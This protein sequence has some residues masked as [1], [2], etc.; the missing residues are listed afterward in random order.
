M[1]FDT[2]GKE[3][4]AGSTPA[5][6]HFKTKYLASH[7][8]KI[9]VLE[10]DLTRLP[11]PEE[12]FF[13]Q[14]DSQFNAFTFIPFISSRYQIEHLYA[15]TY[16]ISRRV[17]AALIELHDKGIVTRITLCISD[18]MIKRNPVT[19]DNLVAMAQSRPNIE[20]LF[21]WVHAK[22]ALVATAT[23]HYVIE[24]SGNWSDNAKYEQY[25]LANSKGLFDFRLELFELTT[26]R[27][28]AE[29]GELVAV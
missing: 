11:T 23:D 8:E 24:G 12:F 29:N 13:L 2:E 16:S 14:S 26:M 21:G 4:E 22:V 25:I 20:V 27:H 3:E 10:R 9:E 7:Y 18:S 5:S 28:K 6:L 17:I 15:T 1:L 19:I